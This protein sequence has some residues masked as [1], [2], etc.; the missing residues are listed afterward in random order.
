MRLLMPLPHLLPA[1]AGAP[2]VI[3]EKVEVEEYS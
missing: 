1:G 2:F 3:G